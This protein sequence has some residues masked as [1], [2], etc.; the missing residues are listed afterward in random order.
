MSNLIQRI[1]AYF[2]EPIILPPPDRSCQR[3][4]YVSEEMM[5]KLRETWRQE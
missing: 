5:Q 4:G 1:R 3:G 2:K